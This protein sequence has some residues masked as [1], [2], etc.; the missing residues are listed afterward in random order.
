MSKHIRL[1]TLL[2]VTENPSIRF[3]I[4]K[5]LDERFFILSAHSREDAL[6]ALNATLD[7]I[8]VDDALEECD[9]L[10]L[11][12]ELSRLT[13]KAL[14]PI[15]LIT[16]RLKKTYRDHAIASGVSDFLNDQL[17]IEEL[18]MRIS[19]G[20]KAAS[21]RQ[22]TE[23][24]SQKIKTPLSAATP[25]KKKFVLNEQALRQ[26]AAAKE[27]KKPV[28]LLFLRIDQS[29]DSEALFLFSQFIKEHLREQDLFLASE[30]GAAILL[31]DTP[32]DQAQAVA[33]RLQQVVQSHPF[34][35]QS[36]P[37]QLT[38]SI[39]ITPLEATEKSFHKRIGSALRSLQSHA[40][41]N[42][43]ISLDQETL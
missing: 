41:N 23:D 40:E 39:A 8:I 24:L 3:W 26:L 17:D 19:A 21:M 5:H 32:L 29:A 9:A 31:F 20:Q 6:D 37:L 25:L 42:F 12:S 34:P 28:A 35:S 16:G 11:C 2:I 33:Q 13:Q 7:F 10:D 1:P 27:T 15:L 4:K 30:G 22:K 38:I 36:G 43:I 14:I 18:G